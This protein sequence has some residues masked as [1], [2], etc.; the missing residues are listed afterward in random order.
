LDK[1]DAH[2]KVSMVTAFLPALFL[3]LLFAVVFSVPKWIQR[4]KDNQEQ[5]INIPATVISKRVNITSKYTASN[6]YHVTF[7][8]PDQSTLELKVPP[9]KLVEFVED[10]QGSLQYQGQRFLS[11]SSDAERTA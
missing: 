10:K 7:L 4:K 11:W 9:K 8:L 1:G 6:T 5:L 2:I 3:V